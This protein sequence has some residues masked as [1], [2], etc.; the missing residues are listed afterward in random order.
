[1]LPFRN[2]FDLKCVYNNG[3]APTGSDPSPLFLRD[4]NITMTLIFILRRSLAAGASKT[5][6]YYSTWL[7]W[8][9]HTFILLLAVVTH[10]I[11]ICLCEMQ[12]QRTHHAKYEMICA[13]LTNWILLTL[14]SKLIDDGNFRIFRF[15]V[16]AYLIYLC[17]M[18]CRKQHHHHTMMNLAFV[19]WKK[20]R[21]ARE[22][23]KKELQSNSTGS[24]AHS[25]CVN[26]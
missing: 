12:I 10:R 25:C 8:G 6:N 1:M 3:N 17:L 20:R 2:V 4:R 24:S 26:Q 15:A 5:L 13:H 7:R 16:Y 23:K 9:M 21:Q 19:N 11:K 18:R 14:K 22:W